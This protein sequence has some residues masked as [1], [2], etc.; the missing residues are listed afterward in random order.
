MTRVT[1]EYGRC[2]V[3][4][5]TAHN[6]A[7]EFV[8]DGDEYESGPIACITFKLSSDRIGADG[9][10]DFGTFQLAIPAGQGATVSGCAILDEAD[11]R[12][13]AAALLEQFDAELD[14]A[15][16]VV[17]AANRF[18]EAEKDGT[19]GL[20]EDAHFQLLRALTDY[21]ATS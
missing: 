12:R 16:P 6:T 8:I 7:G 10:V 18:I 21:K 15:T 17:V 5:N 2:K 9:E 14:L 13:V 11:A 4:L 19:P 1:D 3:T 20:I